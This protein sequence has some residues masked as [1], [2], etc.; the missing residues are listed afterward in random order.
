MTDTTATSNA[1]APSLGIQDIEN[2]LKLIDYAC[3]KGA[4]RGWSTI[5]QVAMHR[6]RLVAF[7]NYAATQVQSDD[8]NDIPELIKQND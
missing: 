8:I 7:I 6:A 1:D 5:E 4:F 2:S 3:E